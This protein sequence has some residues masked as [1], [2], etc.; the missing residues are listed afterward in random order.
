M[1]T[2]LEQGPKS[3]S[4]KEAGQAEVVTLGQ[5]GRGPLEESP[6]APWGTRSPLL[7]HLLLHLMRQAFPYRLCS[8]E[9]GALWER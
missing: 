8:N 3:Q 5:A 7:A 9:E 1:G 2:I 4:G 6:P